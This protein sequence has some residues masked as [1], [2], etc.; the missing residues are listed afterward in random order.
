MKKL[1][2]L[3][4]SALSTTGFSNQTRNICNR[5]QASGLWD[6]WQAGHNYGNRNL[7]PP[8]KFADSDEVLNFHVLGNDLRFPY[9][10]ELLPEY[11]AKIRP[12]AFGV[13]LDTFMLMMHQPSDWFLKLNIPC[14]SFFYFPSDGRHFPLG[15]ERVLQ[16]VDLPIAMSKFG[17]QQVKELFDINAEHIP[18]GCDASKFIPY[19]EEKKRQ[20]RQQ[21]GIPKDAFVISANFRNQGRKNI[22]LMLRTLKLFFERHNDAIALFNADPYDVASPNNVPALMH[23]Y[24]I[25]HKIFWTGTKWYAGLPEEKVID[26]YN[27]SDVN[28]LMTTGE[29][30]C[31]PLIEGMSCE[32]PQVVTDYTT[33]RE[34]VTDHNAGLGIKLIATDEAPYDHRKDFYKGEIT[35]SWEVERGIAD[36]EDAVEKLEWCYQNREKAKQLGKNGRKAVIESYDWNVLMPRWL[37]VLEKLTE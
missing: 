21:A 32:I 1:L 10:R 8:I 19:D 31:I 9:C 30:F 7:E 18:H 20:I 27:C 11:F 26:F 16:K 29:G 13:L 35:G 23:R 37:K 25:T 15:C 3:S 22:H 12:H 36:Y 6:C 24:K 34:I 2:W 28:F 17:Q 4:D 33:T 5:L 14:K